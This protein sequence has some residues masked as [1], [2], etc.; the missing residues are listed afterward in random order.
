MAYVDRDT[1]SALSRVINELLSGRIT[2]SMLNRL[3][4]NASGFAPEHAIALFRPN[5]SLREA[6][7]VMSLSDGSVI[8]RWTISYSEN[9]KK[10]IGPWRKRCGANKWDAGD[11]YQGRRPVVYAR[12]QMG[13]TTPDFNPMK[14]GFGYGSVS[15]L[16]V[17]GMQ[18]PRLG[19]D[20]SLTYAEPTHH[21]DTWAIKMHSWDP[22]TPPQA[23]QNVR[24]QDLEKD[25]DSYT[26]T[27]RKNSQW[28]IEHVQNER[29]ELLCK[30]YRLP[31]FNRVTLPV[32]TS[33]GQFIYHAQNNN[34]I[35]L[36]KVP[37]PLLGD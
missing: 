11:Q 35:F 8:V 17:P 37:A 9:Q 10:F 22:E 16:S 30:N 27:Q 14:S 7:P 5:G 31:T 33:K 2:L 32:E 19:L 6:H 21:I 4:S 3:R 1:L 23:Y 12:C 34:H 13:T 26:G 36:M 25:P 24:G 20:G 29:M 28:R 18:F 15:W